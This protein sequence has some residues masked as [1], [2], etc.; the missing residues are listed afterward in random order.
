[1]SHVAVSTERKTLTLAEVAGELGVTYTTVWRSAKEG[2]LPFPVLRIRGTYR[3]SRAV[4][5]RYLAGEVFD[6][7]GGTNQ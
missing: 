4:M 7:T 1:V 5:D 3:V 2:T 6:T